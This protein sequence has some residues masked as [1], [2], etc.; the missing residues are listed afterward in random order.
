M[1]PHPWEAWVGLPE[2]WCVSHLHGTLGFIVRISIPLRNLY[3]CTSLVSPKQ[4]LHAVHGGVREHSSSHWKTKEVRMSVMG[5][6]CA[7]MWEKHKVGLRWRPETSQGRKLRGGIEG[8]EKGKEGGREW[9]E[10]EGDALQWIG[11]VCFSHTREI[12]GSF[13]RHSWQLEHAWECCPA[14]T[15]THRYVLGFL[16]CQAAV[17]VPYFPCLSFPW[18]G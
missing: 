14:S 5:C 6:P 16:P 7:G 8:T 3:F 17:L 9:E 11:R 2:L 12:P 15:T 18:P 1:P 13:P 4:R 10:H